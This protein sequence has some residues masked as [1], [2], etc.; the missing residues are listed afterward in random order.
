MKRSVLLFFAICTLAISA[1]FFR[2]ALI[3]PSKKCYGTVHY[4]ALNQESSKID[5][6]LPIKLKAPNMYPTYP[7]K[8]YSSS[9]SPITKKYFR[10]KG[11]PLNPPIPSYENGKVIAN[12]F[13]CLGSSAHSLPIR[14]GKEFIYPVLID[15]LN[16][17]QEMMKK[18][19]VITSG[20]RCPNHNR[21]IDTSAKNQFSKHQIG[22]EVSFYIK[23][24]E[25]NN[26]DAVIACIE[27]FYKSHRK[28]LQNQKDYLPL[29]RYELQTD[30]S[31]Q[32]WMNKEIFVKFYLP[33]EGRNGDNTHPYGYF[34]IQV[35]FD[36]ERQLK[37]TVTP[38][39]IEM[40]KRY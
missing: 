5:L 31:I 37:V 25:R 27:D 7:W 20:H 11:S 28:Y 3:G 23:G 33:T 19:V 4:I 29:V 12:R 32:P 6:S 39:D 2:S 10:C 17:I 22:A 15:I 30:T 34:S 24:Q 9:Y 38:Q 21:Y 14:N 40:Y 13:D 36:H 16:H 18:A 8:T 35:R 26:S 1:F